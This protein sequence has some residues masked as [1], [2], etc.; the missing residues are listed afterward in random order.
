MELE[1]DQQLM[2][3]TLDIRPRHRESDQRFQRN[4]ALGNQYNLHR[5]LPR[6]TKHTVFFAYPRTHP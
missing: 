3:L 4:Q 6:L 1:R 5:N 2:C